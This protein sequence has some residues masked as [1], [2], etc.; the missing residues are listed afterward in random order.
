MAECRGSRG[1][2]SHAD[3]G[4]SVRLGPAFA[5]R[6]T[7]RRRRQPRSRAAWRS[8]SCPR[9][10]PMGSSFGVVVRWSQP[11]PHRTKPHVAETPSDWAPD[12]APPHR[13]MHRPS[14]GA[15]PPG[16]APSR[17]CQ[18]NPG[19]P[20]LLPAPCPR[21]RSRPSSGGAST[22]RWR[23]AR[24]PALGRRSPPRGR[25]P[26]YRRGSAPPGFRR[27]GVRPGSGIREGDDHVAAVREVDIDR[28]VVRGRHR[29]QPESAAPSATTPTKAR[30]ETPGTVFRK[31]S[32]AKR[33]AGSAR[34]L[35]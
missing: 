1:F 31:M 17:Q 24:P 2:R 23:I 33:R 4:R 22:R 21:V 19:R 16:A 9:I 35:R 26:F 8:S 15:G 34:D 12:G 18:I 29:S 28:G 10:W 5:L 30:D 25:A 32:I 20:R 14:G 6:P 3:S 7:C 11:T 13:R 27:R